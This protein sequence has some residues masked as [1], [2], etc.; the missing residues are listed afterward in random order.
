MARIDNAGGPSAVAFASDTCPSPPDELV[1]KIERALSVSMLLGMRHASSR[2]ELSDG[3]WEITFEEAV[4]FMKARVPL[5]KA[6]WNDLE[7]KLRFRAF[8]VAALSQ[9]DAIDRVK[10]SLVS[11]VGTGSSFSEFWTE[12]QAL[13]A[14]GL[15]SGSPWYW[16]TV[17]RTNIQ[18]AYN[19]GRALQF[20]KNPPDYLEF[21]GLEDARQTDLCKARSGILLPSSHPWWKTNWPPLHFG[22]RSTV[23]SV[24]RE[25]M[26]TLGGTVVA[27]ARLKKAGSLEN[28][29][30]AN[31]ID[32]GSFYDLTPLMRERAANYGIIDDIHVLAIRLNIPLSIERLSRK[33]E[34][35]ESVAQI[36]RSYAIEDFRNAPDILK[37]HVKELGKTFEYIKGKNKSYYI[38]TTKTIAIE[39]TPPSMTFAHEFGHA[40]DDVGG[41]WFSSSE[42][43]QE[44]FASDL[45]GLI[46]QETNHFTALGEKLSD[47]LSNDSLWRNTPVVSDLFDALTKKRIKGLW[48][49]DMAYWNL[50]NRR[51][52]EAFA[53]LYALT[54]SGDTAMMKSVA[55]FAPNLSNVVAAFLGTI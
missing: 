44:A 50:P 5:T 8:T 36:V 40:Y 51:Q 13:E 41:S 1:I 46:D 30:G 54:A 24:S 11:A 20:A 28:G 10:Q 21:V 42:A 6:E 31:P 35:F 4:D 9:A 39:K 53:N 34:W 47:I 27:P 22:C 29:F 38:P 16:E 17:Y 49:H 43:F 25:E 45:A 33:A 14:A 52:L 15:G 3:P 32:S 12:A 37:N 19:A 2:T 18:G 48:G 23:R 55:D 26:E 7:P